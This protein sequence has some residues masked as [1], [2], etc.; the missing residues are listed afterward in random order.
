MKKILIA[1]V[2]ANSIS[3]PAFAAHLPGEYKNR[4]QCQ[5]ALVH[6]RN[7]ARKAGDTAEQ[8]RL[9]RTTCEANPNGGFDQVTAPAA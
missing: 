2:L 8:D 9:A 3:V 6:A 1:A 4:G 7:E 5:S